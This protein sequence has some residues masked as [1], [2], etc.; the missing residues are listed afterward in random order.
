MS[1]FKDKLQQTYGGQLKPLLSRLA[2]RTLV[3]IIVGALFPTAFIDWGKYAPIEAARNENLS[4]IMTNRAYGS[5]PVYDDPRMTLITLDGNG[6]VVDRAEIV[7]VLEV[8]SGG[9]WKVIVVDLSAAPGSGDG[10][11]ALLEGVGAAA[12]DKPVVLLRPLKEL[13]EPDGSVSIEEDVYFSDQCQEQVSSETDERVFYG[14]GLLDKVST[15]GK[16]GSVRPWVPVV[17][18]RSDGDHYSQRLVPSLS[19]VATLASE[20]KSPTELR[21]KLDEYGLETRRATSADFSPVKSA[22]RHCAQERGAGA[23]GPS[24]VLDTSGKPE[25]LRITFHLPEITRA[26]TETA[27]R[28]TDLLRIIPSKSFDDAD[29]KEAADQEIGIVALASP[30]EDVHDTPIGTMTG[31]AVVANQIYAFSNGE[32]QQE[33]GGVWSRLFEVGIVAIGALS[34]LLAAL[35]LLVAHLY[36]KYRRGRVFEDLVRETDRVWAPA[37]L[38]GALVSAA[39]AWFGIQYAYSDG[40]ISFAIVGLFMGLCKISFMAEEWI[41]AVFG[42]FTN[43]GAGGHG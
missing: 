24:C 25:E 8:L 15:S 37:M 40:F 26:T 20:V 27:R 39:I 36:I 13:L 32:F 29:A 3:I 5:A 17:V 14:H 19:L 43:T 38:I 16:Y 22:L 35:V 31:G 30:G 34:S 33:L 1:S 42:R 11:C 21:T 10:A 6:G 12:K 28:K 18:K 4:Q 7:K 41:S 9:P 2:L 23:T